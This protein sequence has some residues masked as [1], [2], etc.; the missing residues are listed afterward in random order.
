MEVNMSK[1]VYNFYAGPAA[2]PLEVLKTAQKELLDFN[3]SGM[4]IMELSHRS[5]TFDD[6][7]ETAKKDM[8][9]LM[10]LDDS[11]HVLFLGGGASTQFAMVPYNFL[12]QGKVANY[13]DTGAWSTKAIKEAKKVG[14]TH[15]LASSKDKDFS[16]IPKD[17]TIDDNAAYLHITANNTIRG[18]E[19]FKFPETGNIPLVCDMSSDFLS[20]KLDFTK[21][22]LI[23]AGAQKNVGPAGVTIVLIKDSMLK[24]TRDADLF[25]MLD[26]RTHVNK[27]SMFNTPPAFP[28]YIVGLVLKWLKKNGG[29]SE[30]EKINVKKSKLLYDALD[31]SN[32]FYI[33]TTA[34]EDRSRMNVTFRLRDQNLEEE[35]VKESVK[36]GLIGLKGH[37]SVGGLRASIY[38]AVPYKGVE[39]L[40]DFLDKFMKKHS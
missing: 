32:G 14:E 26:Y 4:S 37:R 38:N 2:L 35:I 19:W 10:G 31:N 6:V 34:K 15:V 5:K 27:G 17:F 8:K 7:I 36:N 18:T 25:T 12:A 21:F 3:G 1:R 13:I 40:V 20:R 29:L 16:Y 33:G 30:I 28:I 39:K 9:E 11:Y 24:N 23:Y 22:D